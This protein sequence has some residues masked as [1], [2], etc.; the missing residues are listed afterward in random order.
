MYPPRPG[1]YREDLYE[2]EAALLLNKAYRTPKCGRLSPSEFNALR[3]V[4]TW[5]VLGQRS[6]GHRTAEEF[7]ERHGLKR[8]FALVVP[9]FF[10]AA[11]VAASSNLAIFMPRRLAE[12]FATILPLQTL[13]IPA[14]ALRFQQQLIW[15]ERTRGDAGAV[16]FRGLVCTVMR[17][18]WQAELS[19]A[20]SR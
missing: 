6:A 2:D 9:S 1:I 4:D 15:H 7:L 3:Y 14:P 11:M 10:T 17:R 18:P 16:A 12:R 8:N 13:S 20:K 5:L 19:S